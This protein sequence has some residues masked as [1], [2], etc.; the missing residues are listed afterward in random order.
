MFA[1]FAVCGVRGREQRIVGGKETLPN[2]ELFNYIFSEL[3]TYFVIL[4]EILQMLHKSNIIYFNFSQSNKFAEFLKKI[5]T[6]L[7]NLR[8]ASVNI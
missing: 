5:Q 4:A 8:Q 1:H 6:F 7:M 3:W 2:G